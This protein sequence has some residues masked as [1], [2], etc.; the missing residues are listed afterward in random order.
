MACLA[1]VALLG[2]TACGTTSNEVSATPRGDEAGNAATL[3]PVVV[4]LV[5]RKLKRSIAVPDF[6]NLTDYGRDKTTLGGDTLA[7]HSSGF[8]RAHLAATK[9]FLPFDPAS[10]QEPPRTDYMVK[11]RLQLLG[12]MELPQTRGA[13]R[14]GPAKG[15]AE[16]QVQVLATATGR[17]VFQRKGRAERP[18]DP[19]APTQKLDDKTTRELV[20]EAL[21]SVMDEVVE[22]LLD[23]PWSTSV[24]MMYGA[25]CVISGGSALGLKVGDQLVVV[26]RPSP[27]RSS[28]TGQGP[29][30]FPVEVARIQI[31]SSFGVESAG[32]ASICK[33]ISGDLTRIE[34]T[35]LVV[36]QQV[37]AAPPR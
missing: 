28:P 6:E 17:Q 32:E 9:Q 35:R 27:G 12:V 29:D 10:L 3:D 8:V 16:V 21:G 33:V 19:G 18:L 13:A 7:E 4:E 1:T 22:E 25:N 2:L 26:E 31:E 15:I 30:A 20:A 5:G 14:R 37:L 11:G 36:Q 23:S 24:L 34:P